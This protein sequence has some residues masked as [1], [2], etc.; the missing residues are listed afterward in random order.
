MQVIKSNINFC[1][2]THEGSSARQDVT[3]VSWK[4]WVPMYLQ[5]KKRKKKEKE[6]HQGTKK[7]TKELQTAALN[8]SKC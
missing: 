5:S 1:G 7:W 4:K 3:G 2:T 8:V 6:K